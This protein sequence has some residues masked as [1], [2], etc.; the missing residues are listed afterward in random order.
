M[1]I[2]NYNNQKMRAFFINKYF[3]PN[4]Q[5][6]YAWESEELDDFW[7]DLL[8]AREEKVDHFFGQIVVHASKN[9]DDKTTTLYIIDGQQ[10]ITTS[11]IFLKVLEETIKDILDPVTEKDKK[12]RVLELYNMVKSSIGSKSKGYNLTLGENDK[13]YFEALI[14]QGR[15]IGVSPNRKSQKR[16][17]SSYDFF[18]K[19]LN[20]IIENQPI[21]NKIIEL[22]DIVDTFLEHFTVLYMEASELGEAFTIFETLNARGR[23][24]ETADLLKNFIFQQLNEKI[25]F[26]EEKW[27][28]MIN[29]LDQSD[30]TKYIRHFWN[31][32]HTFTREKQ[33][34][35][36]ISLSIKNVSRRDSAILCENLINELEKYSPYYHIMD[37]PLD[38]GNPFENEE[39][40]NK[41]KVLKTLKAA[42]FY[43]LVLS[44]LQNGYSMNS[45]NEVLGMVEKFIF[46][47]FTIC[48]NVANS[49]EI[50]FAKLALDISNNKLELEEIKNRIKNEME[51]D[52]VF[53]AN[54]E[55]WTGSKSNKEIIRY[56]LRKIHNKLDP[57]NELNINNQEV[58]IEHIM[59][60]EISK[61]DIDDE[62]HKEYLWRLGNLALLSGKLNEGNSNNPFKDKRSNFLESKIE[63]NKKI[64]EDNEEWGPAQIETRQKELAQIAL[65][66]WN[67]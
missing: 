35:R 67:K 56:I 31:S 2:Q 65:G 15:E 33:L 29:Q 12:D 45:I 38:E 54:F 27:N 25:G 37:C 13:D 43:P 19:K 18:D 52:E 63:P 44:M 49:T 10:R 40:K 28:S 34:Y 11:M 21:D 7:N 6:E 3:I 66:I 58:H 26:A 8:I 42:T 41:L 5:R 23:E 30:P 55:V 39:I 4:Y 32:S 48:K 60:E 36:N 47:N 46:R 64:A 51:S 50:F 24:L 9:E 22:E 59:P 20:E 17:K 62:I 14:S 61:W 16:L 1:G 57:Y 53:I